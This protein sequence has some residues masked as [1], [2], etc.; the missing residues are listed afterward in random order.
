ML[1]LILFSII[2]GGILALI[3]GKL[4][5]QEKVKKIKQ[6]IFAYINEAVLYKHDPVLTMKAQGALL[7]TGMRYLAS[8]FLPIMILSIPSLILF[9]SLQ[10]Y[11]GYSA[12]KILD[13]EIEVTVANGS[14]PY[15]YTVESSENTKLSPPLRIPASR[16]LVY[17]VKEGDAAALTAKD[18][19]K[20]D[21]TPLF[22][23]RYPEV[24]TSSWI[25]ALFY[26]ATHSAPTGI[27]KIHVSKPFQNFSLLGVSSPWYVWSIIF[28]LVGGFG[29][30]KI[31][32]ITF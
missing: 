4:I 5:N 9:S 24:M 14:T 27:E 26:G 19:S 10:N 32:K 6:S 17:Q 18:G 23:S 12:S 7:W 13:T 8:S 21:L 1:G 29:A 31:F 28:I 16:E 25:D 22:Q 30:A 11:Y 15:D 2:I 3:Y 20:A